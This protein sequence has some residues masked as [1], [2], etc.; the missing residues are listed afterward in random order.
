VNVNSTNIGERIINAGSLDE[1]AEVLNEYDDEDTKLGEMIDLSSLPSYG[2]PEPSDTRGIWSWDDRRLLVRDNPMQ[3]FI[4]VDRPDDPVRD[5]LA[6][7]L[8]GDVI[9]NPNIPGGYLWRESATVGDY[10]WRPVDPALLAEVSRPD[11]VTAEDVARLLG[12]HY[13]TV[14]WHARRL[15]IERTG[16]D[17]ALTP[18][19]IQAIRASIASRRPGRPPKPAGE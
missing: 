15:G 12:V 18:Q 14:T 8:N 16:R 19:D 5:A 9:A 10:G 6:E 7:R 3:Q 17:Y 1:L 11:G 2:G 4:I 13:S